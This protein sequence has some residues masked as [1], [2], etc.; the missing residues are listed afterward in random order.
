VSADGSV[1]GGFHGFRSIARTLP[2]LWPL[3]PVLYLPGAG[4]LGPRAYQRVAEGRL[5]LENCAEGTC[6]RHGYG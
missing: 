6:P 1:V 3:V 5:R 4:A 2:T